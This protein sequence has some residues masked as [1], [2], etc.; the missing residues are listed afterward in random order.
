M[1]LNGNFK[2]ITQTTSLDSNTYV[3]ALPGTMV[4]IPE[5]AVSF[6]QIQAS[7]NPCTNYVD[8]TYPPSG[9]DLRVT[10]MTGR[11]I[12][13]V[14]LTPSG[15]VRLS[16]ASFTQGEYLYQVYDGSRLVGSGKLL[17]W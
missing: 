10:D 7:P 15:I 13:Q 3:Y 8:I 12:N 5:T 14:R 16:T 6:E 4:D 1:N 11:V 2:M 9:S 17:K